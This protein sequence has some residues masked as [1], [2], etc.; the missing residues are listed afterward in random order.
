M[1]E[2]GPYKFGPNLVNYQ[3]ILKMMGCA[4]NCSN[5][6]TCQRSRLIWIILIDC[7][8]VLAFRRLIPFATIF[9]EKP[10]LHF[11]TSPRIHLSCPPFRS[12]FISFD[13]IEVARSCAFVSNL[14]CSLGPKNRPS[15]L[16]LVQLWGFVFSPPHV[17]WNLA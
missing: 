4:R 11:S 3:R 5:S 15:S 7:R 1:K 16:T 17:P 8:S 12:P 10:H 9:A 6:I 2:R 14:Y 13:H